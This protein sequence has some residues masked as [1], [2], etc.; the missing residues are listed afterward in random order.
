MTVYGIEN[1]IELS[2]GLLLDRQNNDQTQEGGFF[3]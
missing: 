1:W 2:S 3:L